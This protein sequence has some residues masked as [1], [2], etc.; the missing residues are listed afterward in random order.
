M[1]IQKLLSGSQL[2]YEMSLTGQPRISPKLFHSCIR[3]RRVGRP[4]VVPLRLPN[5]KLSDEPSVMATMFVQTFAS[6]FHDVEPS[7]Q[8]PNQLCDGIIHVHDSVI[9]ENMVEDILKALDPNTSVVSDGIPS[10]LLKKN[11]STTG[12]TSVLNFYG[13]TYVWVS[14]SMLVQLY[15]CAFIQET[16]AL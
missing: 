2:K 6:V 11:C 15:C 12:S 3:H 14:S 9:N 1:C 16:D 5:G 7:D 8:A 4:T 10:R 13:F